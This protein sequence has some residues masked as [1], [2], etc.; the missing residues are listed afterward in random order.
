MTH[1]LAVNN[2]ILAREGLKKGEQSNLSNTIDE[3]LS[4]GLEGGPS[5]GHGFTHVYPIFF[6]KKIEVTRHVYN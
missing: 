3:T 2:Q 1:R 5:K 4:R 6:A